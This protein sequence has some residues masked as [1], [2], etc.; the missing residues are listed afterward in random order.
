VVCLI[1]TL[2]PPPHV[3]WYTA[4]SVVFLSVPVYIPFVPQKKTARPARGAYS[5]TSVANNV[6][7]GGPRRTSVFVWGGWDSVTLRRVRLPSL[8][9][10]R[11][12]VRTLDAVGAAYRFW[13]A[14]VRFQLVGRAHPTVWSARRTLRLP[15]RSVGR[16]HPTV[17][18]ARRTLRLP[19]RSVGRVHPTVW[20]VRRTLRLPSR[21]VGRAHPTFQTAVPSFR[22]PVYTLKDCGR[23]VVLPV[24]GRTSWSPPPP[25]SSALLL[26]TT[27][28]ADVSI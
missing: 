22:H 25:V 10:I 27:W 21:S 3:K 13:A 23:P 28:A 5:A 11:P 1:Y 26:K 14:P 19:S 15:S 4:G 20:S 7:G 6:G 24:G 8:N 2:R 16:A 17:W 12:P 9:V 18:S